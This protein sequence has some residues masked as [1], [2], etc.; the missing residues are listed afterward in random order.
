MIKELLK[1][2]YDKQL[3]H[4]PSALSML[5][6]FR[7]LFEDEIIKP[8]RERIILGK[9][10]G[11]QAYYLIWKSRGYLDTIDN[12]SMGV[13][14]HEIEFVDY[15]EETMGN[16][17][18]VAAGIALARPE[19]R[20]WV[21]LTD[22]TLQMGSTLEAIQYIGHNSINN[23]IVTVDYNGM[24][25][26]GETSKVLD[27]S[28]VKNFCKDSGWHSGECNGH[29]VPSIRRL[30]SHSLDIDKPKI[31]FYNTVKGYGVDYM[32]EDPVKWHY[33]PIERL[34]DA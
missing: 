23:I 31:F 16:A 27:V 8:Y 19:Q 24:Q 9:P 4:V 30:W 32:V 13:K 18:G 20:V 34:D 6:Y 10:F 2:S 14:H 11:S 25:V 7:T 5:T 12:L 33:K 26:T 15:S 21:N 22:A 28:P 17:L 29:Y 1:Y 3:T